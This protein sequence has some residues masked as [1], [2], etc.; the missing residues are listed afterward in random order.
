MTLNE[1]TEIARE[2]VKNTKI[3]TE[4]FHKVR[5]ILD[6]LKEHELLTLPTTFEDLKIKKRFLSDVIEIYHQN[7]LV[8][9]SYITIFGTPNIKVYYAWLDQFIRFV[10]TF[11]P[12]IKD[13]YVSLKK[14]NDVIDIL[15]KKF[16][17]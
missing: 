7:E 1:I 5:E 4:I 14:E 13:I 6:F 17:L 2:Q 10:N 11:K 9:S 15:Y 16:F 8:F 3:K 12:K